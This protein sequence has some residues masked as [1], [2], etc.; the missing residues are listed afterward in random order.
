[1]NYKLLSTISYY[2]IRQH[3][4]IAKKQRK[5]TAKKKIVIEGDDIVAISSLGSDLVGADT[6]LARVHRYNGTSLVMIYTERPLTIVWIKY[7]YHLMDLYW[8]L[9]HHR[10]TAWTNLPRSR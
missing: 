3:I 6:G 2:C 10:T 7:L 4:A 9:V 5:N 1:M 8:R